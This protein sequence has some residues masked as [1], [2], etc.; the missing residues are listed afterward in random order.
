MDAHAQKEAEWMKLIS[1]GTNGSLFK[2]EKGMITS[3]TYGEWTRLL[4]VERMSS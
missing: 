4:P 1:K 3:G 2:G